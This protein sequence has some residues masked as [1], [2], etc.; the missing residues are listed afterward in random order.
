MTS[1]LKISAVALTAALSLAGAARA[2][3]GVRVAVAGRA[4]DAVRADV[5]KAAR[6]VCATAVSNDFT[7]AYGPMDEC[8]SASVQAAYIDMK[9]QGGVISVAQVR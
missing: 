2:E 5:L 8:V 9:R 6:A 4:P 7:G 1:I 3:Q